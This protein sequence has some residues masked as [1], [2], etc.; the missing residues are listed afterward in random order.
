MS[1]TNIKII[2]LM[3][4]LACLGLLG[5]QLYWVSNLLKI[6]QE[7]FQ[8]NVF[9]ALAATSEKLEKGEASDI[10]RNSLARDTTL[11]RALFQKI[12]PIQLQ[13]RRRPVAV[14]RPSMVDSMFSQPM[15]Q[16]SPTFQR[17]IATKEGEPK[18]F[19]EI[20]KYFLMPPTVASFVFT[21]DEM[22]IYLQEKEKWL[23]FRNKQD[24]FASRRNYAINRQALLVEEFNVSRDVAE[25]IIKTNMKIALVEEVV[26]QLLNPGHQ[27]IMARIDTALV[28]SEIRSQ[29]L[30]RGIDEPFELGILNNMSDLVTIG[31]VN[32]MVP[33]KESSIRAELFPSDLMG[34]NSFLVIKFPNE[35]NYLLNQIWLPL[36]SSLLF[37][38]IIIYCFI[39]AI[40]VIIHQKKVSEIKSDFINNMT[41][42]FKTPIS[43]VSLAIEALQDPDIGYQE[44]FRNRYLGIIKEENKRLGTQVEQVLQAAALDKKDFKLKLEKVDIIQLIRSAQAH[45]GLIVE[46]R[47]GYIDVLS[48]VSRLEIE[49]DVFH[50]TNIINNLL[51]NANKYSPHSPHIRVKIID[52]GDM[53]HI[54]ITDAG[55]G[56]NKD[57]LKRIFDK[58]YRVPTGNLHDVKGFGL[59][60]SYVKTMVEAHKGTVLVDSESGKGSTFTIILPKKQ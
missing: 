24:R 26:H 4:S 56:M 45:F 50:M 14:Q 12:E 19:R 31:T 7:R 2:I 6:N 44:S 27:N 23:E 11:Q 41:H 55:I 10:L 15:P 46:N 8:Q 34:V 5:F 49:A 42:E 13:V 22:A 37:L 38:A 28:K 30:M 17:L 35:K 33:L 39:Y 16:I 58:F 9:Q 40:R 47:G 52:Q 18:E 3:M 43:T 21:P 53:V 25:T 54:A 32:D 29:L 60:L 57:A 20:E 59:G 51:D 1:K 48:K 36:L